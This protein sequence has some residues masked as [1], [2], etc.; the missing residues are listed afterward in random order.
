MKNDKRKAQSQHPLFIDNPVIN[1]AK[2]NNSIT[3]EN[4][5]NSFHPNEINSQIKS[6]S[7][8]E[9]KSRPTR[10][11]ENGA[12]A[13]ATSGSNLLDLFFHGFVRGCERE[14]LNN[15]LEVSWRESPVETLQLIGHSRDC[16]K[17]KG[18]KLVSIYALLWLRKNK[19]FTYIA[20]LLNYLELGYFKDLLVIVKL[21]EEEGQGTLMD[22]GSEAIELQLMAEFLRYDYEQFNKYQQSAAAQSKNTNNVNDEKKDDEN[23]KSPNIS[24]S[25]AAKWAPTEKSS[26]DTKKTKFAHRLSKLLFPSST[27]ALKEY[28]KLLSSLRKQLQV[29]EKLMCDNQW[30]KIQ[31]ENIPSKA[32]KLIRNALKLHQPERYQQYLSDVKTGV[33]EIKSTGLQPHELTK[34]YRDN[35]CNGSG[36]DETIELQWKDLVSKLRES[37]SFERCVAVVDVS[38]SMAGGGTPAPM[39]V[40]VALG[41]L[42]SELTEG[43]YANRVLT[44]HEQPAWH[45]LPAMPTTLKSRVE[46]I[47]GAPWGGST[48]IQS[49]FDLILGFAV[50]HKV[51]AEI[52]PKTLFIFSDMQFDIACANY[53]QHRAGK[54]ESSASMNITNYEMIQTKYSLAGYAMPNIIFWNLAGRINNSPVTVSDQGTAM[55]SGFS[56][57]LL[58]LVMNGDEISPLK[59]MRSAI[60]KYEQFRV[61]E[62]ER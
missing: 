19:P 28:R 62:S 23:K 1:K 34:T 53:R 59:I 46:S 55:L 52:M 43:P 32:H 36:V 51:P 37:G 30:D 2:L 10:K 9:S 25:L 48:N 49:T 29:V 61:V 31:F 57:E 20:N 24:L 39:D 60:N 16:R 22:D 27:K 42:V 56:G 17:G 40:A 45:V 50:E 12:A 44:F 21:A 4:L 15:L 13:F 14:K 38:G 6:L 3:D 54:E 18:E 7:M 47:L 11:T 33:K 5:S 35:N 8:Q 41:L 58:K 26:F